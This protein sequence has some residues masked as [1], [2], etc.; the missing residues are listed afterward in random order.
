VIAL[1]LSTV[2]SAASPDAIL[3]RTFRFAT[4]GE[5]V[6]TLEAGCAACDWGVRG[7]EAA[8]LE[9]AV[10][11]RY[12]QHVVLFRGENAAYRLL[13]GPLPAGDHRLSVTR[14]AKR[15]ARGAGAV[16]ISR[17]DVEAV[18]IG[19]PRY[20]VV[21]EAPVLYA[22]PGSLERFSD[23]PLLLYSEDADVEGRHARRYTYV[24]S[25]EDG[26]TPADRLMAT[27]GRVT[28]IELALTRAH[29]GGGAV[30]ETIQAKDH[31]VRPFV[32]AR[33]GG[34]PVLYVA[35][36]NNMFDDRGKRTVRL[37]PA[38]ESVDLRG[39]SRE[40]VMDAHGWTYRVSAEEVRREGRVRAAA[41]PG[42]KRIP[43]PSRFVGLEACG[44]IEGARVAFDLDLEDGRVVSS[45]GGRSDFRIGRSGCFRAA[46]A[47]PAGTPLAA[48]RS[49]RVRAHAAPPAKGAQAAVGPPL[50]RIDSVNRVFSLTDGAFPSSTAL[51]WHGPVSLVIEGPALVVPVAGADGAPAQTR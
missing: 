6:L 30:R 4:A 24:F 22:R 49:V 13:L 51:P 16:T 31:V 38:P 46:A 40:A 5:A 18:A 36:R 15:S 8:A 50:V 42:D 7:R 25:N 20:A 12:S 37:A 43:D 2:L 11:G 28:D 21:A 17:A 19:D 10:D 48:V 3:E 41:R 14:D 45:D 44:A 32:G 29:D 26:G 34:H 47:L 23:V 27:W 1:L 9:V 33:L 35:T 39:A